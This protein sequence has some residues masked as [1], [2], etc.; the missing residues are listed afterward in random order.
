MSMLEIIQKN[1]EELRKREDA[2]IQ[3]MDS[4]YD[5]AVKI[6]E[7]KFKKLEKISPDAKVS[8]EEVQKIMDEVGEEFAKKFE[9]LIEP[10]REA[11]LESYIDSLKETT[12]FLKQSIKEK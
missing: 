8:S 11:M 12:E 3:K 10:V 4:A 5:E 6:A 2:L 1:D 7:E 9:Q